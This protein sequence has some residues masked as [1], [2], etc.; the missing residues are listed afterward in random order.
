[1][2]L[3]D[4]KNFNGEVFGA[5]V[6]QTEN[7]NRNELLK[8][9]AI[10]EKPQYAS[11]LPD[12]T[13]G[14]YLTIPIKARI[15]GTANNYDGNTN[16]TAES[17]ETYTQSRIV[18]GR[19]NGWTEKDFSSDITGEDFLPAAQEIAEYWDDVDQKTI[20]AIL[21]G[22]FSMTGVGNVDFVTKHTYDVSDNATEYGFKE[23]TLNNAIQKALGD[24][25]A[26]FSLAIMHSK[27]ATDLENLK[28][29]AYMKYTDA[30]GIERDLT[31]GTLNGR[32]VLV[33]DNMPTETAKAKY[34][35]AK[36]TDKDA[37]EV[38]DTGATKGQVNKADVST[39][40]TGAK[41]GDYVVLL[42][43]GDVYTTYVFGTGAIE[44]TD[45]GAKV[46]YEMDRNP[47]KNGGETTLYSR[48]RKCWSPVGISFKDGSIIS[49]TDEE[50][51]K[52]SNWQLA[53][54][55]KSGA[56]KYFPI[57]A[58]PIARIKTRG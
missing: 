18:V 37:L 16:I 5:Y 15:G 1:M 22:I 29:L 30:Q 20:L 8:S 2:A 40:V 23:T 31:L 39:D 43:A 36:Q 48:Q 3:F 14:N 41:A 54:N 25:K 53:Q 42:P 38:V 26:K 13:G 7:L 24:N 58:I 10:V 4:Q 9:G 28:L 19:A 50:L 33:D 45:C 51:E 52:G 32:T 46:P 27:V 34:V 35:K 11:L 55:N 49:P 6:D 44:Y 47:E 17:R 12:Q 21:K 57:K 56:E